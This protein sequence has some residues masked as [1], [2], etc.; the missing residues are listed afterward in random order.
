MPDIKKK[1][2]V[3]SKGFPAKLWIVF[4]LFVFVL[5]IFW[6]ITHEIVIEKET[7]IDM[8]VSNFMKSQAS[9]NLTGIFK[10]ITFFGSRNFLLPAYIIIIVY[11]FFFKKKPNRYLGIAVVSLS[12][13]GILFLF[14][15]IFKR[16]RPINSL[17]ENESSFSYPSGHSFS[18]FVLCGILIYLFYNSNLNTTWK[19]ICSLV[20]FLLAVLVAVSRIYLHVHYASDVLAGFCLSLIWMTICFYTFKHINLIRC[21]K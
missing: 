7:G 20:V 11:Y 2:T 6:L 1:S 18:A 15:N 14:K 8:A 3:R 13:A 21:N 5:L 12:G 4:V 9:D 10:F 16:E 17:I 19:W